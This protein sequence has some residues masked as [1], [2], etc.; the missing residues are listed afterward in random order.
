MAAISP[1]IPLEDVFKKR[2]KKRKIGIKQSQLFIFKDPPLNTSSDVAGG[3]M[4]GKLR[5]VKRM[6]LYGD[7]AA[8][9][10]ASANAE[11]RLMDATIS[12]MS[13]EGLST[14]RGSRQFCKYGGMVWRKI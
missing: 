4:Q 10:N 6:H 3:E 5:Q 1:T 9:A 13:R 8:N 2:L 7:S 11:Q 12:Y 14:M